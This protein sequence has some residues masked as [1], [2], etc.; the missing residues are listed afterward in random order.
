MVFPAELTSKLKEKLLNAY[1]LN[2]KVHVTK[3]I[4]SDDEDLR[5]LGEYVYEKVFIHYTLKQWGRRPEEWNLKPPLMC[6]CW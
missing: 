4:Q 6:R 2:T 5:F 3:L 1:G